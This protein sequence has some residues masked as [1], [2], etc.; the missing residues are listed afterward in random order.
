[1]TD[2]YAL[3]YTTKI[4]SHD[5]TAYDLLAERSQSV[6]GNIKEI[7]CISMNVKE[8]TKIFKNMSVKNNLDFLSSCDQEE[9]KNYKLYYA[10]RNY[11]LINEL[12]S[13]DDYII[14]IKLI[15]LWRKMAKKIGLKNMKGMF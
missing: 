1:M 8:L 13:C 2:S 7:E 15:Q 11:K 6:I 12:G 4:K 10:Q 14:N 5:F 9:N 3:R